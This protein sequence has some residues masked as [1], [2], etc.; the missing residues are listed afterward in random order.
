[1]TCLDPASRHSFRIHAGDVKSTL[2][3]LRVAVDL[4]LYLSAARCTVDSYQFESPQLRRVQNGVTE[5]NSKL[6]HYAI[7]V[8]FSNA[9][10]NARLSNKFIFFLATDKQIFYNPMLAIRP[11]NS[12]IVRY[13]NVMNA[14]CAGW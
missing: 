6:R 2:H 12:H 9:A 4:Q 13:L 10:L 14:T 3:W 8:Q 5:L 7:L 11:A 1:M